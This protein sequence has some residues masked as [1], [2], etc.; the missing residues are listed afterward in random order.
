MMQALKR[1]TQG[2]APLAAGAICKKKIEG[3]MQ[4]LHHDLPAHRTQVPPGPATSA[5]GVRTELCPR[6][7]QTKGGEEPGGI[8]DCRDWVALWGFPFHPVISLPVHS[9]VMS[10]C[11]H[12]PRP[13][14]V[15]PGV[16]QVY[17]AGFPF[18][19]N[20]LRPRSIRLSCRMG[21]SP[22]FHSAAIVSGSNRY[23]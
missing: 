8:G 18:R 13:R 3:G 16:L 19:R 5:P 11:C 15:H 23:A 22:A 14:Q 12:L 21:H 17:L 10:L 4:L 6:K 20:I 1:F 7:N 2:P 9:C